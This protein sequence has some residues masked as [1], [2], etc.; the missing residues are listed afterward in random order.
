MSCVAPSCVSHAHIVIN[1]WSRHLRLCKGSH[2]C[3]IMH[4]AFGCSHEPSVPMCM[5]SH[6]GYLEHARGEFLPRARALAFLAAPNMWLWT[7]LWQWW[8][9]GMLSM[10]PDAHV[11]RHAMDTSCTRHFCH[12]KEFVYLDVTAQDMPF[13]TETLRPTYSRILAFCPNT[14]NSCTAS[15][16]TLASGRLWSA[17]Q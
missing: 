12:I 2:M 14:R 17:S 16:F 1:V 7:Y 5:Q 4:D 3:M 10:E 15:M 9:G 11:I 6:R 8:G 13:V